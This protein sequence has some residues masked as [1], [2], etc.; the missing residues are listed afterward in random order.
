MELLATIPTF[1]L[2][3]GLILSPIFIFIRTE[4]HS[5]SKFYF[6]IYIFFTLVL[7]AGIMVGLACWNDAVNEILLNHYKALSFNNDFATNQFSL[8]N[9]K[10]ENLKRVE[11]LKASYFGIGWPLK[12]IMSFVFYAPYPV[13]IYLIG[14]VIRRRKNREI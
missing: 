12:A 14:Q 4:K 7:T 8:E 3:L 6:I 1:L 11:Q 2:L 13:I 9:V 5:Q 10:P